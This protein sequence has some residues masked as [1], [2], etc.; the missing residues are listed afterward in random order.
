[1]DA[2]Q[3]LFPLCFK[4]AHVSEFEWNN[5]NPSAAN[6]VSGLTTSQKQK[7]T[8][9]SCDSSLEDMFDAEKLPQLWLHAKNNYPSL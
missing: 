2:F 3:R 6:S 4:D 9:K 5:R 8:D 7:L 1:L